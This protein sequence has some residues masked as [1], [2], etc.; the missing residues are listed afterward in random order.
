MLSGRNWTGTETTAAAEPA[1]EPAILDL[2]SWGP[3]TE[4]SVLASFV[5]VT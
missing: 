2:G 5:P 3:G 4:P 1:S